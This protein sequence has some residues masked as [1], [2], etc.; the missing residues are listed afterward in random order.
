MLEEL[1]VKNFAIIEDLTV[2]FNSGMTVLTGE[3]GAGKS[4]IIDTISLL[5]GARADSDMIRYN[6]KFASITGTFTYMEILRPLF[7]S[8]GIPINDKIIIHREIYDNKSNI[9]KINGM[10]VTLIILRKVATI[11]ADLHIQ[12]DTY[13][14]FNPDGYLEFLDDNNDNKLTELI[15]SYSK[16]LYD[17]NLK[18]KTY[19]KILKG[20]KS[21]IERI[22]FLR[23][24]HDEI[25][26]LNL[27]D[28]I[29]L[30]LEEKINK[31]SNYDKIYQSLNEA[32]QSLDNGSIDNIYEAAKNLERIG[33][34]S[35]EYEDYSSKLMDSYYITSEIHDEISKQI[36]T[37]DYDEDELNMYIESLNEI[38]KCK[39]KYKKT[40]REL[41]K[42]LDDITLEIDMATN[43]DDVLATAYNELKDSY[44]IL[45]SRSIELSKYRRKKA[46]LLE[47]F[48]IKEC[49]ELDLEN[50]RFLIRLNEV[51]FKDPLNK[52]IFMENGV[53]HPEFLIS[54][55]KG[56]PLKPLH[57]VASGGEMSRI[58][59][60]FKS[61]I[62]LENKV[63]LMVFDE[64]DTGVSGSTAK[65]IAAKMHKIS[66]RVQVLCITHL[67]Q[68][69]AMGDN[70]KR[71][72][73]IEKN[74][75]TYTQI[76]DLNMDNRIEE[77]A[78]MLSGDS[79]SVYALE[80][81]KE[82]INSR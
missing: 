46:D 20:Q 57:K 40:V 15:S 16:G 7:E 24:E 4:L 68:V 59:L 42:Y 9:C 14:L 17:Y 72:Y 26:A 45:T 58:M 76:D 6:Q 11:L 49:M 29:D 70:H 48:I 75:R 33:N 51:E 31:L 38:N 61:A 12:N 10:N 21:T 66:E 30:E 74:G 69:A 3:T 65:K 71:I 36:S 1:S 18:Y 32:Y 22:D 73:K 44:N 2:S 78:I 13:K 56:E 64:I 54:F 28:G 63:S 34:L 39:E 62:A 23:Y 5:L 43:Y 8:L 35:L 79:I 82:L 37:L 60:A 67:P 53:D 55:N 81:A 27:Y 52:S 77:I 47:K 19:E 50:T 41:I 80:H 25:E